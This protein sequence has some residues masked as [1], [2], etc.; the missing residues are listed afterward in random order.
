M[1]DED[2][3]VW[4]PKYWK[5]HLETEGVPS[6]QVAFTDPRRFGRIRLV[7]CPGKSI[8]EHSPLVENGPDPLESRFT[9]EYLGDK[10]RSRHV[11]VKAFILD[12]AMISGIGNW[13]GDE[14]LYHSRL[15][16]EQYCDSFSDEQIHS[17]FEAIRYVCTL[18]V[19]KLGDSDQ[20]PA[21]WLFNYRWGKGK[22]DESKRLPN[23][24]RLTFLTVGGRTSCFAPDVQKKTGQVA[25]GVK[26]EAKEPGEPGEFKSKTKERKTAV[27]AKPEAVKQ[28]TTTMGETQADEKKPVPRRKRSTNE[29]DDQVSKTR[30]KKKTERS[31]SKA[32]SLADG[33]ADEVFEGGAP[34]GRRRSGRLRAKSSHFEA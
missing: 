3:D 32:A 4:P 1:K 30:K 24:D 21:H 22:K 2:V 26:E 9:E 17:L 29:A 33:D 19:E 23:G 34:P 31:P 20:F 11:P 5:F 18:A 10:M 16:P 28:R 6:V 15:H 7:D 13:V 12:Q 8:R 14:V 27:S 25:S